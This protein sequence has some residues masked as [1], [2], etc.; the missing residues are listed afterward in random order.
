VIRE[1]LAKRSAKDIDILSWYHTAA[2]EYL[3]T[4]V[5]SHD[6]YCNANESAGLTDAQIR[7]GWVF[8][9]ARQNGTPLFYSR[10]MNSTRENY[11]GDNILGARGNDEFFHPEVVAVNKFRQAM[12]GEVED[13]RIAEDG[14]VVVVN[15]GDKGAAV[16]NFAAEANAFELATGL[17]DGTYTDNVY[18]TAFTVENGI[19]KGTAAP[20]T[21]YTIVF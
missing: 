13:I 11:W 3:T 4:W 21:T 19:L 12:A 17:A 8:L 20:E 14:E 18:G 1:V 6:T 5:E 2:P 10:P 16:I 7:T 15:R 9:T